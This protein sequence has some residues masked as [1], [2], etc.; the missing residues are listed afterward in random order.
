MKG[1]PARAQTNLGLAY[2]NGRGVREDHQE[3]VRWYRRAAEQEYARGQYRLGLAYL[4]G[5]GVR[6]DHQEAVRWYRRAAEQG[7]IRQRPDQ[8]RT[9][10]AS[11]GIALKLPGGTAWRPTR[12]MNAHR[13]TSTV[14]GERLNGRRIRAAPAVWRGLS[15]RSTAPLPHFES[16]SGPWGAPDRVVLREGAKSYGKG[17][18]VKRGPALG[19]RS[20]EWIEDRYDAAR[21]DD[22]RR[23]RV[24]AA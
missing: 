6:E 19:H 16:L 24:P 9:V 17:L 18:H 11:G 21:S 22:Q 7:S 4:N 20:V 12:G 23:G 1:R 5:R 2:L 14:F 8:P 10:A 15:L 3:A 13:G